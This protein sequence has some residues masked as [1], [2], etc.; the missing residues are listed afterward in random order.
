MKLFKCHAVLPLLAYERAHAVRA[1]VTI[2]ATWQEAR[3]RVREQ[4]GNAE[5]VT[6]PCEMPDVWML[7]V[8]SMSQRELAD[9]RS[10]CEWKEN[11]TDNP[12]RPICR[13][14]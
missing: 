8:S 14:K 9:L 6:V 13:G 10:A 7:N 5:F 3:S 12:P 2:A 1:Y 11:R 4:E